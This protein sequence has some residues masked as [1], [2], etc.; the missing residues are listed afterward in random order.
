V[1]LIPHLSR[2][3]F[4]LVEQVSN[5]VGFLSQ[6]EAMQVGTSVNTLVP[7][8][9]KD[10]FAFGYWTN[11]ETRLSD[12][13][14][15]SLT[16]AT[17]TIPGALTLTAHYFPVDEDTDNDGISDW[18]EYR[19]FGDLSPTLN[20]D[21]D[22]DGFANFKEELLG[23]EPTVYDEVVDG[24]I[25]ARDTV[26]L[27]YADPSL[28]LYSI[29]SSPV[30]FVSEKT[31]YLP[32]GSVVTPPSLH[33]AVNGY[34][35]T[36]WTI[37]G[38]RQEAL[39][40]IAQNQ[41]STTLSSEVTF[42]AHYVRENE[43]SDEDGVA[44]WYELNQFGD[45]SKGPSDDPENDGFT[46]AQEE[47]LGQ[48]PTVF[49]EVADGGIS[50]RDTASI[51][52]ADSALSAYVIKSEPIGF[53][54]E[55]KGYANNGTSI[56]TLSLHG[57]KNGYHFAYWTVNGTRQADL[58]G[59]SRS[60]A[61]VSLNGQTTIIA[62]YFPKN[63]D[64]DSDGVADWYEFNQ[65]GNLA[66]KPNDDP[67]GD[68][69]P[70]SQES[71]LGQ[72]AAIVDQVADGGISSRDTI[73]LLYFQSTET[74]PNRA[75]V[76]TS[77][78]GGNTANLSVLENNT[79]VTKLSATDPDGDTLSYFV[80]GGLD[81]AK[82]SINRSNGELT[83]L[84]APDFEQPTDANLDNI[85]QVKV[86]VSDGE[87]SDSQTLSV[88]V[89]DVYE[90]PPNS[91][92]VITSNGGGNDATISIPENTN[93]VT[94]VQ[95]SD[96]DGDSLTYYISGGLDASKFTMQASTGTLFF[97]SPPDFENPQDV[98]SSNTYRVTVSVSD[99]SLIDSQAIVVT[100]VDVEEAPKSISLSN[101]IIEENKATGTFVGTFST[102]GMD[103]STQNYL[104]K[105]LIAHYPF[106]GNAFDISGN[107]SDG[108]VLGAT[109]STDR[110]GTSN[111]SYRFDGGDWIELPQPRL[112]DQKSNASIVAWYSLTS[113]AGTGQLIS[114][115]D[116]RG[117]NDPIHL[118]I[119]LGGLS[120]FS[121]GNIGATVDY[122]S[123]PNQWY[124]IA[125]VLNS[126]EANSTLSVYINGQLIVSKDKT[127]RT[128]S[129]DK[130]MPTLV[131]ALEGRP[132]YNSPGQF[133]NGSIDDIRIYDRA[134]S[135]SE[136][137]TLYDME[138]DQG[139]TD[140]SLVS[141]DGSNGNAAFTIIG[142]E[143]KTARSFDYEGK[144]EYSIR[145]RAS[146]ETNSTI[147]KTFLI[148]V[149]NIL[150]N[151]GPVFTGNPSVLTP[152]NQKFVA[153]LAA[154]DPDGHA[155]NFS[156]T[157]GV[158]KAKFSI[159]A[160]SG[161]LSFVKAPDFEVP[162]DANL[163]NKYRLAVSV[164]DGFLSDSQDFTITVND[165]YEAPPNS[166]PII[167]SNGGGSSASV[168]IPENLNLATTIK[169]SDPDGNALTF[170]LTG[171]A[172]KS[173]FLVDSESGVLTFIN[174][175]DYENPRDTGRNNAYDLTVTV[176]DGFL[177]DS[178]AITITI[179][180]IVENQ[181]PL[182]T[183]G[184]GKDEYSLTIK[185]N[186]NSVTTVTASDQD[187]NALIYSLGNSGE[188]RSKFIIS[189]ATGLLS[190]ANA[191]DFE[192]PKD[193]NR[194]NIYIV[195]VVVSDGTS[196][197]QQTIL[198]SVSDDTNEDSDGDGLTDT[199]E[200][201]LGTDPFD[202]DTDKD[203]HDDG[204][205][206]KAGTSPLDPADYP[207]A[208]RGFDFSLLQLMDE[209]DDQDGTDSLLQFNVEEG[210]KYYI[211]L[212]GADNE[213]GEATLNYLFSYSS[214]ASVETN[215][216]SSTDNINLG[217]LEQEGSTSSSSKTFNLVAE[218]DGF[219]DL[220]TMSLNDEAT[221]SVFKQDNYGTLSLVSSLVAQS[222]NLESQALT[223]EA[224]E[225]ESYVIE[226]DR[227]E[228]S[229]AASL[230]INMEKAIESP[231]NDTFQKREILTGNKLT[232]PA[233]NRNASSELGEPIHAGLAPPQG[234]VWWKWS[235]PS[236]GELKVETANAQFDTGLA[237]Y[238]G[239]NLDDLIEIGKNDNRNSSS[240]SS[241][242]AVQVKQ[243][244][245]YS[246]AVTGKNGA[247][248]SFNLALEF[249]STAPSQKP[250]N[251]DF[252]DATVIF[253]EVV[254][255]SSNNNFATEETGE[256]IAYSKTAAPFNTVWWKWRTVKDGSTR[257]HTHG[258]LI[259]TILVAYH[260]DSIDN[261]VEIAR[262]DDFLE[263]STSEIY[264]ESTAGHTYYFSV[265]GFEATAGE[266]ELALNHKVKKSV[267]PVNDLIEN[268]LEL[269]QLNSSVT[270]SNLNAT[271]K[272]DEPNH[273]NASLPLSSVWW[274]L[275]AESQ[276][277]LILD[278]LGSSFDTV[279]AVYQ[280]NEITG[281]LIK[282][283]ENDDYIARTS[284]VQFEMEP[285]KL[286]YIAIDGKGDSKG[287]IKL[288]S[289]TK[290]GDSSLS[291]SEIDQ[292]LFHTDSIGET[293][294]K[295]TLSPKEEERANQ[296]ISYE[297][298]GTS[299][300]QEYK[301]WRW[302]AKPWENT[303]GA[304]L[305]DGIDIKSNGRIPGIQGLVRHSGTKAFYLSGNPNETSW[306]AFEKWLYVNENSRITWWEYLDDQNNAYNAKME[307]SL[308]GELEWNS[309]HTSVASNSFDF[310]L[311][312]V[313]LENLVG[314]MAKVRFILESKNSSL[315]E[316][317]DWYLDEINFD[318][319]S[320]LEQPKVFDTNNN[321]VKVPLHSQSIHLLLTEM[322]GAP[323][324]AKY[325]TPRVTIGTSFENLHLFFNI[326]GSDF[327][328]WI[329]S[330]WYGY[331]YP[332]QK[333]GWFYSI[334]RGWQFFGGLS[335]DGAWIYD[336]ELGWL[337]TNGNI[338]PWLYQYPD[339]KWF[340]DYSLKTGK[341][342]FVESK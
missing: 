36:Y 11:G 218:E 182:I 267:P 128:I 187:G 112:L 12:S 162:S 214:A 203:G 272:S 195:S 196:I 43:D 47:A 105:G 337:W 156:L 164:S 59:V 32:A 103:S 199:E 160:N 304:E 246:F 129:Y 117:G 314:K 316:S 323:P 167:T 322:I 63:E 335:L 74:N 60:Q 22:G 228:D 107:Q 185:E 16:L 49:D 202:A 1:L 179:L 326:V 70:N 236:D 266:I 29:T 13:Q 26:S 273:A 308:D 62:H 213:Q 155:L 232:L 231:E 215:F 276:D 166:P 339:S 244:V 96:S 191:P 265:D 249:S 61:V 221:V 24:G 248:G 6:K 80:S 241:L 52:Y 321:I 208:S 318:N 83:F 178:Q 121:L 14:G 67:D 212:D 48:E 205:E 69:Y 106:N 291:K 226:V 278:T 201:S 86:T 141:G 281:G 239:W 186:I 33:G 290:N 115:G 274:K 254:Q 240:V 176:S 175:P 306:L 310:F 287:F 25:S 271:G 268:A 88:S 108:T 85:Y 2:A 41:V 161:A 35:F 120:G 39:T 119:G 151:S 79:T 72:E 31:E 64:S 295:V 293:E 104:D 82:F 163:D 19:N 181:A 284:L 116:Y 294:N 139:V 8:L 219:I 279:L 126:N 227:L 305:V 263:S 173:K 217:N 58:K 332:S 324:S 65:F 170:S 10:G 302:D 192:S 319:I 237:I 194:N 55:Q 101:L 264:F 146:D 89:T 113:N 296:T 87:L 54:D 169:A 247:Q 68:G 124:Q 171:G 157:G 15:R 341:R 135:S 180:N 336:L 198:V 285:G 188:D 174:A 252:N 311:K 142:S 138:R 330:T 93:S 51:T 4:V 147:E 66:Q 40:G 269:F 225:G 140:Y 149:Q 211:A 9:T 150:E 76:I 331:F 73:S 250:K 340:Y 154:N 44:D 286:Y 20:G 34:Q 92:P 317:A 97:L 148:Q 133:F 220:G 145:V 18:F 261:L 309:L 114:S 301:V 258:S 21:P 71:A 200:K 230:S 234:S 30:G 190:F 280:F 46:N 189:A 289:N 282:L 131:G 144:N 78:G 127:L 5:P 245:E 165:V 184:G 130:D 313:T 303:E 259:D 193:L 283:T 320:Y 207:G 45:L 132:F 3:E 17:V 223:F 325:S 177:S 242:V 183:S 99:N 255:S 251:D 153:T 110:H 84:L 158:D 118:R 81:S 134:L 256:P 297:L 243:G 262:N 253:G 277:Q 257:V 56:T 95:A 222:S 111:S 94:T 38:V 28:V 329:L 136:V 137:Q 260:G 300:E 159:D 143:L 307:Y 275:R 288:N 235:A 299:N 342:T 122:T 204:A 53:V 216:W 292:V 57:E 100:I 75:P 37:N 229:Q 206:V 298:L 102:T 238:A 328:S 152:E 77:N 270:G 209:N 315:T 98:N 123:T 224:D 125:T 210:K 233:S 334:N 42:V 7:A 312:E 23:Q 91:P 27:T 168:T 50:A 109:L 172:D 333:T 327:N 338:Y 197:D 90:A